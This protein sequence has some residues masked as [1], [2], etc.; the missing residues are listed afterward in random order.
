MTLKRKFIENLLE[1]SK[2]FSEGDFFPN[3]V[4]LKISELENFDAAIAIE[5][6]QIEEVVIT[7]T[8]NIGQSDCKVKLINNGNDN[9]QFYPTVLKNYLKKL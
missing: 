3:K 7:K 2:D 6:S 1:K 8:D 5:L 9:I 4:E